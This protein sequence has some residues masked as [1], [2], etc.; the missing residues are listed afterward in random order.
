MSF[1]FDSPEDQT[2]EG[3]LCAAVTAAGGSLDFREPASKAGGPICLTF[4]FDSRDQAESAA[5]A[6]RKSGEHVEGVSDYE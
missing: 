5:E 1:M 6:L 2:R 3:R 4:T